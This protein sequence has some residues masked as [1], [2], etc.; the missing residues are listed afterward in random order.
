MSYTTSWDL[1]R[2]DQF[3]WGGAS[4]R[5]LNPPAGEFQGAGEEANASVAFRLGTRGSDR[6][7]TGDIEKEAQDELTAA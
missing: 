6:L 5:I 7:C 4:W 2:G 3:F 1:T